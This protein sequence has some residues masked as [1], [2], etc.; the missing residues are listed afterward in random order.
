M[1]GLRFDAGAAGPAS[2]V[3][4]KIRN[5]R[6][7]RRKQS[8]FKGRLQAPRRSPPAAG[9]RTPT[10]PSSPINWTSW[11]DGTPRGARA[12]APKMPPTSSASRGRPCSEGIGADNGECGKRGQSKPRT[13]NRKTA[14][15]EIIHRLS[16]L[17]ALPRTPNSRT[18][19][20]TK[21]T[22]AG[23]QP[24]QIL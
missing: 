5:W 8:E 17:A 21:K 7:P 14:H 2:C 6:D 18:P 24:G 1:M 19:R 4:L 22:D 11:T 20:R 23:S 15:K 3:Q 16:M 10:I 12:S 13:P 9:W